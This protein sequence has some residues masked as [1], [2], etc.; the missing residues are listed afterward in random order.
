VAPKEAE[1][2]VDDLED[3]FGDARLSVLVEARARRRE[4]N[5]VEELEDQI[6]VLHLLGTLDAVLDREL[7]ELVDRF[8][9]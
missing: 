4:R 3:P 9:L 2:L 1:A 8:R 5:S 6:L 7:A